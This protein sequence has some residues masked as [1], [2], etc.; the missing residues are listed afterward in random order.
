MSFVI[1]GL[2]LGDRGTTSSQRTSE[3]LVPTS[4]VTRLDE[5][6]TRDTLARTKHVHCACYQLQQPSPYC[7]RRVAVF[8]RESSICDQRNLDPR[9]GVQSI[10]LRSGSLKRGTHDNEARTPTPYHAVSWHAVC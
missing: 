5:T 10:A 8:Q 9:R 1:D 7:L 2:L 3:R 4:A 6:T